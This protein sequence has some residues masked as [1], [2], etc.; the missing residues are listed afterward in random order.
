M[1][2]SGTEWWRY[3]VLCQ[4][5]LTELIESR[6]LPKMEHV[7]SV[8]PDPPQ[9]VGSDLGIW[10]G[11][12]QGFGDTFHNAAEE[13]LI[14]RAEV[15]GNVCNV[16]LN[17]AETMTLLKDVAA[18]P[19]TRIPTMPQ[20]KGALC[21]VE[22]TSLTPVYPINLATFRGTVIG[23]ATKRFLQEQGLDI[24]AHY[25][26]ED[27][28][29]QYQVLLT[30]IENLGINSSDV[31]EALGKPDHEIGYM[32]TSTILAVKKP[33]L[34]TPGVLSS[35]FPSAV[36]QFFVRNCMR[37]GDYHWRSSHYEEVW[38]RVRNHCLLGIQATLAAAG[39]E[40]DRFDIETESISYSD[41]D[42]E[43]SI[44]YET[45]NLMYFSKLLGDADRVISIVPLGVM[46]SPTPESSVAAGILRKLK[47]ELRAEEK[48]VEFYPYG[49]VR[50]L[51]TDGSSYYDQVSS[52]T[53]TSVDGYVENYAAHSQLDPKDVVNAIKLFFLAPE[54][55]SMEISLQTDL[56]A[57]LEY[58]AMVDA[59]TGVQ[60][61]LSSVRVTEQLTDVDRA[62]IKV[63]FR[64]LMFLEK[65]LIEQ[66]EK[67][68]EFGRLVRALQAV[69]GIMNDITRLLLG[70][71]SVSGQVYDALLLIVVMVIRIFY[72][73][74]L[75][76]QSSQLNVINQTANKQ[77][78][79][80]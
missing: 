79:R 66:Y 28:A 17:Y 80:S 9:S 70:R 31:M 37:F 12:P 2:N 76:I 22:H 71:A 75:D 21:V 68:P 54:N 58:F 60:V 73:I 41:W 32:Y 39:I 1:G 45:R 57:Q 44:N 62:V 15:L 46:N 78:R 43:H 7:R 42:E 63:A 27:L 50:I 40:I 19:S 47:G 36:T 67:I 64:G 69:S 33:H 13:G 8:Q 56:N 49:P 26:V 6:I 34:N 18:N 51:S 5:I 11:S 14:K 48:T 38:P 72:A 55:N 20:P 35:M 23:N 3:S 59:L 24:E 52:G 10:I 65:A 77:F 4:A 25:W 29:R 16:W 74:G 30:A 61:C 53:Y